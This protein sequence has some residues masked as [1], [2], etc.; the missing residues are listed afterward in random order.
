MTYV[1]EM[2]WEEDA[3]EQ[4]R[5]ELKR[6]RDLRDAAKDE[7]NAYRRKVKNRVDQARWR[8]RQSGLD[9]GGKG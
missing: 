9:Q 1:A 2:S 3:T 7:Y 4:E 8:E 5:A 6:L